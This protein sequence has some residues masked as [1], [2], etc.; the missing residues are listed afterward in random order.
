MRKNPLGIKVGR[1]DWK[2]SSNVIR[3]MRRVRENWRGSLAGGGGGKGSGKG[4][5]SYR[6]REQSKRGSFL[7]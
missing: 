7:G 1:K 5:V 6:T 4:G 3:T 2:G